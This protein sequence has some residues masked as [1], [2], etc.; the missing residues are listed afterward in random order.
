[1]RA[2]DYHPD[3]FTGTIDPQREE[4]QSVNND[5]GRAVNDPMVFRR[6][7]CVDQAGSAGGNSTVG[8]GASGSDNGTNTGTPR[9]LDQN[10][11]P[12]GDPN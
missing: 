12:T 4:F 2:L 7:G 9:P 8:T 3:H 11:P 10:H 1:M 6:I 5:G